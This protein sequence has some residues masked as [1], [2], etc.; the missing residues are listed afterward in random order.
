MIDHQYT[1]AHPENPFVL[2]IFQ[3]LGRQ[4]QVTSESEIKFAW[5]FDIK[6]TL[7]GVLFY[8]QSNIDV[9]T[10]KLLEYF[11][12]HPGWGLVQSHYVYR[13][14]PSTTG[15]MLSGPSSGI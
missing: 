4:N 2:L 10:I 11:R 1:E 13:I 15:S 12:L 9:V 5:L 6:N 14:V 8:E 7:E 3:H